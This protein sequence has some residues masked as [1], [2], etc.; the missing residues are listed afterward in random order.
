MWAVWLEGALWFSCGGR[1]RK[2]RNLAVNPRCSLGTQ[3][4]EQP[5]T[6]QGTAEIVTDR[7]RIT[8]FLAASNAKYEVAYE[9]EFLDPAVNAT[10]RVPPHTVIGLRHT[11]FTGS[12]TRWRFS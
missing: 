5:V 4:P 12:P 2:R 8:R 1:S 9:P 6:L 3:D 11:D 7:D 10:D